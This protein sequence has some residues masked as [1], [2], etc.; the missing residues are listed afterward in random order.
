MNLGSVRW[1][2]SRAV[3]KNRQQLFQENSRVLENKLS[4]CYNA[5]STETQKDIEM[6]IWNKQDLYT[7]NAI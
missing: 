5:G 3:N 6:L 2:S 4:N 7:E 1:F